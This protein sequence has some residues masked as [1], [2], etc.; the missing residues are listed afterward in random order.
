MGS[1]QPQF[2]Q[3]PVVNWLSRKAQQERHK[4]VLLLP[5]LAWEAND[6]VIAMAISVGK[7]KT[8]KKTPKLSYCIS[9]TSAT[10]GKHFSFSF[11]HKIY[12][13]Q[14]PSKSNRVYTA[15][16]WGMCRYYRELYHAYSFLG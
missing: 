11:P 15:L 16:L 10:V 9:R 3:A 5:C 8:N 7:K 14:T 6:N 13:Q 1:P 4:V 12:Y 2:A